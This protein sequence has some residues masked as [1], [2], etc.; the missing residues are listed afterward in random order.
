MA[1]L[2]EFFTQDRRAGARSVRR[3]RR[4]AA[5]RGDRTRTAAGARHRAR[6]ALGGRLRRRRRATWRPSTTARARSIADLGHGRSRRPRGPSTRPG[7]ELRVGDALAILPTLDDALGRLRRDRSAV[8]HPA[9]A[10]DGRRRASPRPTRT[11]EPTTRWSA[12]TRPI[13]P[14]RPTTRPTSTGWSAVFGELRRVLRPGRYAVVI[15]RDAYQDGRYQFVGADL[16]ARAEAVGPRAR[17]AI[18]SGTRP[19]RGCDRTAIRGSSSRTSPTSTSW[20]CGASRSVRR[21][22]DSRGRPRGRHRPRRRPCVQV[23]A[24]IGMVAVGVLWTVGSPTVSPSVIL[25]IQP[26]RPS[27]HRTSQ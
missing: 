5:R 13:S 15:V 16:A 4:D 17:R 2:I 18:S 14:T 10:D 12:T 27:G 21:G 23:S 9:A 20:C 11:G 1:R 6:S 25:W 8:Q 19:G 3:R 22:G 26:C 24:A 7:C